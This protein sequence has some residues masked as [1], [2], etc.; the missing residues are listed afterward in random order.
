MNNWHGQYYSSG[1]NNPK[2]PPTQIPNRNMPITQE[3][4]LTEFE[5]VN[6]RELVSSSN[7]K[8]ISDEVKQNHGGYKV[9][10]SAVTQQHL[11]FIIYEFEKINK[12]KR[13]LKSNLSKTKSDIN[14]EAEEPDQLIKKSL[15]SEMYREAYEQGYKN[16]YG[17]GFMF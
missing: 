17:G 12:T 11:D 3:L 15:Q 5:I 6:I 7:G 1:D 8:V 14:C 16:G 9:K 13:E 4:D 10:L 2:N